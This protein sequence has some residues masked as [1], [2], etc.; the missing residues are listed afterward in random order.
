MGRRRTLP[1]DMGAP[2]SGSKGVC[3]SIRAALQIQTTIEHPDGARRLTGFRSPVGDMPVAPYWR[4]KT[5]ADPGWLTHSILP[6]ATTRAHRTTGLPPNRKRSTHTWLP[7]PIR[8]RFLTT[9]LLRH[10]PRPYIAFEGR[11]CL[12]PTEGAASVADMLSIKAPL[13][14]GFI[15]RFCSSRLR[16]LYSFVAPPHHSPR[17]GSSARLA[18][19]TLARSSLRTSL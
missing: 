1:C 6:T 8:E 5:Y 4:T 14:A 18:V 13:R 11:Y 7:F 3:S 12:D 16:E 10:S 19:E 15:M 2:C 9:R 17:D